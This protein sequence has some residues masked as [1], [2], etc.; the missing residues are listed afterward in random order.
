M[1]ITVKGSTGG[2]KVDIPVNNKLQKHFGHTQP[3]PLDRFISCLQNLTLKR[4]IYKGYFH[5]REGWNGN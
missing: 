5:L 1:K 4:Y 2:L 3:L